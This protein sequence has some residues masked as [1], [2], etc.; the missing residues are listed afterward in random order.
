MLKSLQ[1]RNYAL[2][3][4]LELSF[5][6][7]AFVTVTGETGAGKSILL[8][9]LGLAL[10]QR[11]DHKALM[12][13]EE[14]CVVEAIFGIGGYLLKPF[15]EHNELDY[16][17]EAIIRREISPQGKSRAFVNDTPV[18]LNI[19]QELGEKL[20]DVHSQHENLH[21][22]DQEFQLQTTDLVAENHKL[23]QEYGQAYKQWKEAV[24]K[25]KELQQKHEQNKNELE[26]ITYQY[27]E[28]EKAELKAGEKAQ[29]EEEHNALEHAGEIAQALS[30]STEKLNAEDLGI[31]SQ[32]NQIRAALASLTGKYAKAEELAERVGSVYIELQDIASEA[33]QQAMDIE[34][35]PTREQALAQRLDLLN[36]LEQK[37]QAGN[38]DELIAIRDELKGKID[39]IE[40]FSGML[41]ELE[42]DKQQCHAQCTKQ[43]MLLRE[44]R[45]KAAPQM[46]KH[47]NTQ[48]RQLGMPHGQFRVEL[49]GL[50]GPAASGMDQ[51]GFLFTANKN[52][53]MREIAAVASGGELSRLMLCIKSLIAQKKGLP[54]I[55]FDEIDMGVSGEIADKMGEIMQDMSGH[56]QVVSITHLPQ[57]AARGTI[58]HKVYKTDKK[59]G[60][61]T[62]IKELS[63]Q[64]ERINEIAKMLSGKEISPAAMENARALLGAG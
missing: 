44:S 59:E 22:N 28:L 56:M 33:E 54:T 32:L 26:Y 19:L 61:R 8:G 3:D 27:E 11:A 46:E 15:F 45:K 17:Q 10:G 42:K 35:D 48:L 50:D 20:I 63:N 41:S 4:H 52:A 43:A 7:R 12:N 30:L 40:N 62:A 37:H 58:H 21:L 9:A 23:R 2:I 16:E 47:I 6:E 31:L 49:T 38:V 5:P 1:I 24:K 57:I 14:K 55:I 18:K 39:E 13:K 29:L 36:R 34:S 53:P 60:T 25:Y 51:A 64:E